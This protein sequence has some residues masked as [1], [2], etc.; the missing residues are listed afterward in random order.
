[1]NRQVLFIHG[2][3]GGGFEED[4]GMVTSLRTALGKA[5]EVHYPQM[6]SDESRS[7]FGWLQKI[8]DEITAINGD[9]ILAGHSLGASML[10]KYLSENELRKKIIGIFLIAPPF[11]SGDE[12]WVQGL[13]L[14]E[15][16]QDKMP[17]AVPVFL[18]H[19][20]DDNEVPFDHLLIY[21]QKLSQ[22]TV[23]E[24][25]NGGHQL[26]NDLGLVTQ[27]IKSL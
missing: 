18:Y 3:G 6:P 20:R 8:E 9:V 12:T 24:I 19:C 17:K 4:T 7:D 16:F 23:R 27:D 21:K 25:A 1:M 2:G 13:K 26:N 14:K 10:L 15:D 5:Y 22:A 11:W